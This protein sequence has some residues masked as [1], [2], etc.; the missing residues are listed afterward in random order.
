LI[1]VNNGIFDYGTKTLLPFTPENVFLTKS[2]IDYNP[3]ASN[4]NIHNNDDSTDWDIE[5][6]MTD[7]SDDPEIVELLWQVVGAI[8]RPYVSWDKVAC[9]YAESG[10]NG[11]GTLCELMR[12]LCGKKNHASIPFSAFEKQFM[13]QQL[14][15]ISAIITDEND[16]KGFNT[17]GASLKAVITGDGVQINIK[18]KTP[19][20]YHFKG[21]MVQCVNDLPRFTDKSESLY[22]RFLMIPFDKC[23]T[24]S[25]RKYIKSDYLARQEVLEYVLHKVLHMD[26][27]ELSEPDACISLL[28]T[29]KSFNDPVRQFIEEVLNELVWSLIPNQFLYDLYRAWFRKNS[30]SG[31]CQSKSTFLKDVKNLL[32]S[33]LEWVVTD[34]SVP[35][36]NHMDKPEMLIMEYSLTDWMNPYYKGN[37]VNKICTPVTKKSYSGLL[38]N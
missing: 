3:N 36:R 24:G 10:S 6:W 2:T 21:L 11:K 18:Y 29:S 30:P 20:T 26:Y 14:P 16:V 32:G 9:F 23:F 28:D 34:S 38:R 4:I 22:R 1:A 35:T 31:R 33:H 8:I 12:N 27:Y 19:I 7:L 25:E 5:S 37:D 13:L 17:V 15:F